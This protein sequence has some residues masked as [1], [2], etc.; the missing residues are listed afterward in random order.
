[1]PRST[2]HVNAD[3]F[4]ISILPG[5]FW[6]ETPASVLDSPTRCVAK[7][8]PPPVSL[9]FRTNAVRV[10]SFPTESSEVAHRLAVSVRDVSCVDTTPGAT[11]P[12]VAKRAGDAGRTGDAADA[13]A[14]DD[15]RGSPDPN[16]PEELEYT[17][18][19]ST[20][21]LH[22]K[23]DQRVLKLLT[24]VFASDESSSTRVR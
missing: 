23:L 8:D 13:G 22:V 19:A 7:D 10:D 4:E 20:M 9:S 3:A 16:V 6:T 11:W 18:R 24:D 12:N 1:M 5:S 14:L 2:F 21:P 17:V 15:R